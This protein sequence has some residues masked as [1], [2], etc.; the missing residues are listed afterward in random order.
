VVNPG[1]NNLIIAVAGNPNAGK[2]TIFNNL[3]GSH[4]H[5]GNYPGVTVELSEG[6][7]SRGDLKLKVVDLPGTYSLTAF[8]EEELVARDF[9]VLNRPDVVVNVVDASNLER[10]LFLTTE[11]LETGRPVILVLNMVDVARDRNLSIDVQGLSE[12]LGVPVVQAVGHKGIGM[13][14]LVEA[15]GMPKEKLCTYCWD[16]AE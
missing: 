8:S 14:D 4:Q 12:H 10:N 5:V 9:L 15:I 1:D 11:L 2:T 3:T 6:T 16:G 13:D 7:L